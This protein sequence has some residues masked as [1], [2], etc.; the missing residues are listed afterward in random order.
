VTE[1]FSDLIVFIKSW[2]AN[3]SQIGAIAPS[4]AGLAKLITSEI[5]E[6]CGEIL[7]LGPG[8]GVFT[9][10]ILEKIKDPKKLTLV[11]YDSAMVELLSQ[12][13]P[14]VRIINM[15]AALLVENDIFENRKI[16]AVISGMPLL[17][18]PPEV[19]TKVLQGIFTYLKPNCAYYQF[20]YSPF[21]PIPKDIM[22]KL[23]LE[24]KRIGFV[25]GNIPPASV[26]KITKV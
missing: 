3:P 11:E 20:T 7:E 10:A 18:F 23:G 8:T 5:N 26:F 6:S 2:R 25:I 9:K 21:C 19:L 17:L 13:F 4:S 14:N 15:D 12:R 1:W 22:T 24:A 16:D